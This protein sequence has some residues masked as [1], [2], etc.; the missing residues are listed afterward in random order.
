MPL[1]CSISGIRG[2]IG[3]DSTN[4]L[5]PINIVNFATAFGALL[6]QKH[7]NTKPKKIVIGRDARTTGAM[8][9]GLVANTLQAL[10]FTVIDAGLAT[11]P[12]VEMAVTLEK[13]VGGIIISA[14]HNPANWNALKL[15]NNL[16]E[17]ISA[18]DGETLLKIA[19][20]HPEKNIAFTPY[21]EIGSYQLVFQ[22][23]LVHHIEQIMA[24][25][26][27]ATNKIKEKKFKVLVDGVNS[28]GS[29]A[30]PALLKTLGCEV[31]VLNEQP[32]GLFPRNPEPLPEHL[33][34]T[35]LAV[36]KN[37]CH[38]GFVVDPDADRL[39]IIDENGQWFGEEYTLVACADYYLQYVQKGPVVS[40]L[41]STKALRELAAK[42]GCHYYMSAV[43]EVNVVA[44]MK[45]VQAV[46]GGEGNGGI[47][48]P[49]LHYGRDALAGVALFLSLMAESGK[50]CSQLRH[51]Y[52]NYYMAKQKAELPSNISVDTLLERINARYAATHNIT[53]IDG[54]FIDFGHEWVHLRK[55][56]TEPI[57]RVY[58]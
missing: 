19:A 47:I 39:A 25:K 20:N 43:G 30:L 28:V 53:T 44:Q 27:I 45:A 29:I 13:A 26:A 37:G 31:I 54:V 57:V 33:A 36:Q 52:P 34:E 10:G 41:S 12:T 15:L 11:T 50:T 6:L 49:D 58:A 8:V 32:S 3:G 23:Y 18:E 48:W 16:G 2:T 55:S 35:M 22:R 40:N 5:T 4:A 24:Q 46:L 42:H 17:F 1:I 21:T 14:S 56:N 51:Q 38:V 9:A 7:A